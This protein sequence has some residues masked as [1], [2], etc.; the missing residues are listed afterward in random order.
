MRIEKEREEGQGSEA[1][2]WASSARSGAHGL[3]PYQP[4]VTEPEV[5]Q[6]PAREA[7]R[8]F[9]DAARTQSAELCLAAQLCPSLSQ[10]C[11]GNVYCIAAAM[12]AKACVP[13]RRVVPTAPRT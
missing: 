13:R 5:A 12:C 4:E 6:H 3:G 2:S 9:S 1:P 7:G 8:V 11:S 10:G